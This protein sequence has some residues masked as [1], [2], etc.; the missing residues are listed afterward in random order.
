MKNLRE[1]APSPL[2]HPFGWPGIA[3][4]FFLSIFFSV[5]QAGCRSEQ[6]SA[7]YCC[8]PPLQS[9]GLAPSG[10]A[11]VRKNRRR[12]IATLRPLA[13]RFAPRDHGNRPEDDF[14]G[15]T[16]P[17]LVPP[18]VKP[19]EF[20]NGV[21]SGSVWGVCDTETANVVKLHGCRPCYRSRASLRFCF[22]SVHMTGLFC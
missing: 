1:S 8:T 13:R 15:E 17:A 2:V 20:S 3:A 5:S 6:L 14:S 11:I 16:K 12:I 18:P 10:L 9:K 4:S 19:R 22:A 21:P 7:I